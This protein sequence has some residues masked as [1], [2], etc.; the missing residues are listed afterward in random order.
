MQG[1]QWVCTCERQVESAGQAQEEHTHTHTGDGRGDTDMLRGRH[2]SCHTQT[3]LELYR[4]TS[5]GAVMAPLTLAWH[6]H[7]PTQEAGSIAHGHC[8]KRICI[9]AHARVAT[10]TGDT[11][12]QHADS[13]SGAHTQ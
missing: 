5:R 12:L 8:S 4:I 6:A 1:V 9:V 3:H 11:Q 10:H 2:T 13:R 7:P